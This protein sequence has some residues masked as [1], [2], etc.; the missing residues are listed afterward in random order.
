MAKSLAPILIDALCP[1]CLKPS[2]VQFPDGFISCERCGKTIA[3][4]PVEDVIEPSAK[5]GVTPVL[6]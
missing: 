2:L 5:G 3:P 6:T 1:R 4:A